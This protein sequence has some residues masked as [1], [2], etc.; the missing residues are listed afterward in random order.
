LPY[1]RAVGSFIE[2]KNKIKMIFTMAWKATQGSSK[3]LFQKMPIDRATKNLFILHI[4]QL[5]GVIREYLK[6]F[7]RT[8]S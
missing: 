4:L 1:P 5:E 7:E 2:T 3:V 6:Y 8:D